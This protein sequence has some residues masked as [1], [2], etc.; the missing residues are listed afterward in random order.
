[1]GA[2]WNLLFDTRAEL[3]TL[4]PAAGANSDDPVGRLHEFATQRGPHADPG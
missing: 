2:Q 1:M 4:W 3:L